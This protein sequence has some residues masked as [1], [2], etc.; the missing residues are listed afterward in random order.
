M[1]RQRQRVA[2]FGPCWSGYVEKSPCCLS[3]SAPATTRSIHSSCAPENGNHAMRSM[4][5]DVSLVRRL[6]LVTL[7]ESGRIVHGPLKA[8][9]SDIPA[10]LRDAKPDVVAI[11]SPPQWGTKG[12]SRLIEKQLRKLGI[13]IYSCPED[14]GNHRF[15]AWMREGFKVFDAAI[16]GGFSRYRGGP[17][18]GRQAIEVFPHASGVT[19]R[20]SL[21]AKGI[22]K[23]DWRRKVLEDADVHVETL[24]TVDQL[25]AGLAAVTGVRFL[26]ERFS[27]VGEPGDSVL[28]L[29]IRPIVTLPYRRDRY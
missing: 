21:P 4:G 12:K 18:E 2:T 10:I 9:I 7:S 22:L 11:D 25:D 20:G 8:D 15:Y 1:L 19:L 29:P 23:Q 5:I 6:D 27:Y 26:Q 3:T 28:V 14:P 24:K 17:I 16:A 13:N